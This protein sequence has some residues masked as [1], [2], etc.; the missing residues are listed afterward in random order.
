MK[1]YLVRHGEAVSP[2]IDPEKPLSPQGREDVENIAKFLAKN[3]FPLSAI[4]H[5]EKLRAKQTAQIMKM[6]LAPNVELEEHSYLSP[7]DPIEEATVRIEAEDEDLMIVSHLPFL[8]KLASFL[9]TGHEDQVLISF[10]AGTTACLCS[11]NGTW[12][13]DWIV[14]IEQV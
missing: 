2:E 14:G 1:V 3:S 11:D 12:T 7:N 6:D 9:L 10:E 13:V 4:L 8:N 5:S